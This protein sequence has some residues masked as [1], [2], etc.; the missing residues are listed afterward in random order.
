MNKSIELKGGKGINTAWKWTNLFRV[1]KKQRLGGSADEPQIT[2]IVIP[3]QTI[4]LNGCAPKTEKKQPPPG[5]SSWG[6]WHDEKAIPFFDRCI[7]RW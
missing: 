4:F 7:T 6:G 1:S 3:E 5:S 2:F